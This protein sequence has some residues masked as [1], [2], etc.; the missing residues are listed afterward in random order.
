VTEWNAD[1][2]WAD[3]FH[4]AVHVALTGE[5]T[6][7]YAAYDGKLSTIART[8]E[9]GWLYQGEH[10]APTGK[11]RGTSAAMLASET[12]VYCL[13][14]HDQVG[15]RAFGERLGSLVSAQL[16]DA[17][18]MLL[19]FLPM[20]PLLFMGQEWRS[21]TPF[22]YFTDHA[23]ELGKK[24]VE[25][26]RAEHAH[27]EIPDPQAASTF[28]RSRLDWSEVRRALSRAIDRPP[29]CMARSWSFG[30]KKERKH[31]SSS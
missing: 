28:E 6:G 15:N 12:F 8:I 27:T 24:I 17:V 5:R 18:S 29:R 16:Y 1:A 22:L 20:T 3:D 19:L 25:G 4:H 30:V 2:I 26:R 7:Y 23:P 10:Y 31:A 11:P 21:T 13:Q 14:N 9:R